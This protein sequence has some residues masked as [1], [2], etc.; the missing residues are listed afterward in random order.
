VKL[1]LG[2][3]ALSFHAAAAA[4]VRRIAEK[5]G[6]MVEQVS[7]PHADLFAMLGRGDVDMACSAWLPASH[8]MYLNPI[9]DRIDTLT[10]L[11][12]PFCIWGVPAHVPAEVVSSIEDLANP[13]VAERFADRTI[14]GIAAGAGISRFSAAVVSSYGLESAGWH[15]RT[16]TEEE[17]FCAFERAV[18]LGDWRVVPLWHPQF[19]HH[20]HAVRALADPRRLLGGVDAATLVIRRDKR[21]QL[22]S[23]LIAQWQQLHLGNAAVSSLDWAI[24]RDGAEPLAAADAY[25]AGR[26]N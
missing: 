19:L 7:A 8:G 4:V 20:R 18:A 17:C 22:P 24:C 5:H 6:V 15:F 10:V 25:L 21:A 1:A 12:E 16:G 13:I 11:Y 9:A 26:Q 3:I 23:Q 2:H 14:Q